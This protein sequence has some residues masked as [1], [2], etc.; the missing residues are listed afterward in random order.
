MLAGS[1]LFWMACA[2]LLAFAAICGLIGGFLSWRGGT[3]PF[4]ATLYGFSA[5]GAVTGLGIA[6]FALL[7]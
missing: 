1:A 5:Y 7:A 2:L 6:F 3:N 4:K